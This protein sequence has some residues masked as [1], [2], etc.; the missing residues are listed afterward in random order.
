MKPKTARRFFVRNQIKAI[1]GSSPSFHR[2]FN[3]AHNLLD[4]IDYKEKQQSKMG[5]TERIWRMFHNL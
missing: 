1:K 5:I 3:K 2:R 4:P